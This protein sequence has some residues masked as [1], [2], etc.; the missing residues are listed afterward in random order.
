MRITYI[1]CNKCNRKLLISEQ[2]FKVNYDTYLDNQ[3]F[4]CQI[5]GLKVQV[6]YD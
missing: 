2:R 1:K 6:F 5:C 3:T 4:E